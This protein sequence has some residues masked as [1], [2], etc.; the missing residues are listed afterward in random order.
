MR[1]LH[2][3][4]AKLLADIEA[5]RSVAGIDR[6]TFGKKAARDGHFITRVEHGR[7]PRITTI[8]QV[9]KYMART[10]SAVRHPNPTII[11]TERAK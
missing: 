11:T 4:A 10:T 9:Y 8:E 2:P 1:K 3:I 7:L 6:T 5:Y